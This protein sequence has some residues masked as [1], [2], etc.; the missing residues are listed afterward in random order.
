MLVPK[1]NK[2]ESGVIIFKE[3][4][5]ETRLQIK[6]ALL[7]FFHV[8]DSFL[9]RGS[10]PSEDYRVLARCKMYAEVMNA[11]KMCLACAEEVEYTKM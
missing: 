5:T 6:S 10:N 11:V 1:S 9:L 8:V 3:L 2:Q 7:D 4:V